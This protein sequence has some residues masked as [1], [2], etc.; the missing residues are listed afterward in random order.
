MSVP[1]QFLQEILG[2]PLDVV[3]PRLRYRARVGEQLFLRPRIEQQQV[4]RAKFTEAL[5]VLALGLDE[6]YVSCIESISADV[7][8]VG[9][10]DFDAFARDHR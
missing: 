2:Y 1:S 4:V 7:V 8:L 10:F 5:G 3:F 9:P 6:Q